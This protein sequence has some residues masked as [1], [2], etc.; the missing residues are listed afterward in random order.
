MCVMYTHTFTQKAFMV[1]PYTDPDNGSQFY[2]NVHTFYL[3]L[4]NYR[5]NLINVSSLIDFHE[6]H[7]TKDNFQCQ[8]TFIVHERLRTQQIVMEVALLEKYFYFLMIDIIFHKKH[9]IM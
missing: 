8:V 9:V 7:G 4:S 5:H 6:H 3:K 2:Q 1:C